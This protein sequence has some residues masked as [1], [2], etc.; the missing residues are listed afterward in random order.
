MC[1][2]VTHN[3]LCRRNINHRRHCLCCGHQGQLLPELGGETLR[4]RREPGTFR[5]RAFVKRGGWGVRRKGRH[6]FL[7]RGTECCQGRGAGGA[8]GAG[9][10]GD[11]GENG[12]CLNFL[13]PNKSGFAYA[14]APYL[15]RCAQVL[16]RLRA[17]QDQFTNCKKKKKKGRGR[18][19][20]P[21]SVHG[22]KENNKIPMEAAEALY[23]AHFSR[24]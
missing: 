18:V 9:G 16:R 13:P 7:A 4:E 12:G 19:C 6:T 24:V 1:Q 2:F 10:G 14:L 15:R 5:R 21:K 3:S 23:S 8:G 11:A 22:L 17:F 20:T